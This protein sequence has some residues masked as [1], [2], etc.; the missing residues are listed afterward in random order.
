VI[1]IKGQPT[2]DTFTLLL[3]QTRHIDRNACLGGEEEKSKKY[4][5][6]KGG[7]KNKRVEKGLVAR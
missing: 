4:R 1:L 3:C 2:V 6:K 5:E 7:M